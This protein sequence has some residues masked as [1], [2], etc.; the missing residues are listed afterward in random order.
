MSRSLGQRSRGV[1]A[2]GPPWGT[3]LPREV[4]PKWG[5]S[6]QGSLSPGGGRPSLRAQWARRGE[7]LEQ[8]GCR[9]GSGVAGAGHW[10][11]YNL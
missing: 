2:S 6:S 5:S 9:E 11:P 4:L 1:G 8:R 10:C 3:D 7:R